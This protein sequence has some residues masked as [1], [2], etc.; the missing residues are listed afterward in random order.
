MVFVAHDGIVLRNI[1]DDLLDE[2]DGGVDMLRCVVYGS[3]CD[4]LVWTSVYYC[5]VDIRSSLTVGL[6]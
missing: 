3:Q 5:T 4:C 2:D 6:L 1:R